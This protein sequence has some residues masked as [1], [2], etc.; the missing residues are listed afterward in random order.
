MKKNAPNGNNNM[1]VWFLQ[2]G[3]VACNNPSPGGGGLAFTG[4]HQDGDI[5]RSPAAAATRRSAR[6]N[7]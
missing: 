2:D 3:S 1:G 5:L 6:T 4:N 7:G